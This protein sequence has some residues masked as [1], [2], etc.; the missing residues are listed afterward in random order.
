MFK[1]KFYNIVDNT[2]LNNPR[3]SFEAHYKK[4]KR[5]T[6]KKYETEQSKMSNMHSKT[7]MVKMADFFEQAANMAP[8]MSEKTIGII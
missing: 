4:V 8:E 1:Q 6:R 3:G 2:I 7:K 5:A